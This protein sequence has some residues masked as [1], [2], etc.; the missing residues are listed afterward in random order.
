M[1]LADVRDIAVI[2]LAIES[3]VVGILLSLLLWQMRSLTRLLE[4][5]IKPMLDNMQETI[6]TVRGT[7]SLVSQTIV[8]PAVKLAGFAA[9]L[10]RAVETVLTSERRGDRE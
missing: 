8:S 2:V 6:G 9:G 5:E 4:E 1:A 10:R 3:I 7:T